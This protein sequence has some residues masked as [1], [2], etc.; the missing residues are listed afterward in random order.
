MV[1]IEITCKAM[2][3]NQSLQGRSKSIGDISCLILSS[4][5]ADISKSSSLVSEEFNIALVKIAAKSPMMSLTKG[6][7]HMH[8]GSQVIA[9]MNKIEQVV[10]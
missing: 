2:K 8:V 3:H 10:R 7:K 9:K 5:R 4:M 1:V 6:G